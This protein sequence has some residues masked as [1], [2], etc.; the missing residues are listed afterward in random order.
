MSPRYLM[1]RRE[2]PAR[3]RLQQWLYPR[4]G[5]TNQYIRGSH[6]WGRWFQPRKVPRGGAGAFAEDPRFE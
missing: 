1:F 2:V 5:S 4:S 6:R 3:R